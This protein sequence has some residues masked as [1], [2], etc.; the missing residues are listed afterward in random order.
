M[1]VGQTTNTLLQIYHV[2]G[3]KKIKGPPQ[4]LDQE[5]CENGS[6]F[7]LAAL[8]RVFLRFSR[9]KHCGGPLD[10]MTDLLTD[11]QTDNPTYK[12]TIKRT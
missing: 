11:R 1:Q 5:N 9:S 3:I 12:I 8:P 6:R 10:V 7:Y 2:S 4:C